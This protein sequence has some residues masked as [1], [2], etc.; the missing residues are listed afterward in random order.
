MAGYH[1]YVVSAWG[2]DLFRA[3]RSPAGAFI[4]RYAIGR[5]E[6]V[7]ANDPALAREALRLGAAPERVAVV[8]LGLD[9]DF[10]EAPLGSVNLKP[11]SAG[12]PTVI[13]D[14]ALEPLYNIDVVIRAFGRLRERLPAAR[15]VVA[16]QGSQREKLGRL[17]AEVGPASAIEFVGQ[18]D[19]AHLQ[20]LL[21][22]AHVYVSAPSSDSLSL[23]TMEAMAA[24]A[25]PVVSDLPS[26]DW[27][28][29]RVN[30]LRVPVREVEGLAERLYLALTDDAMRREAVAPNRARVQAEGDLEKNMLL[31]ERQYYRL[32][33]RP[34]ADEAL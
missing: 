29:D 32:A 20:S 23:S 24:G 34:L 2:S 1:P 3:P 17:A 22:A 26:Q 21:S 4:A 8:R 30:G 5:A 16:G 6:L 11:E 19:Q 13:S 12:P 25:F 18:V 27:I 9:R 10:L 7:T 33:G 31:M 14:R 28:T 15:L